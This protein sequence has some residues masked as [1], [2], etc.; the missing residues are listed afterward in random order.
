[1]VM[2]GHRKDEGLG[3]SQSEV[4]CGHG[5]QAQSCVHVL[6]KPSRFG[7]QVKSQTL[8]LVRSTNPQFSCDW[9]RW[10]CYG[11]RYGAI[12]FWRVF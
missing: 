8:L 9:L 3:Y 10:R 12:C 11:F 1:M 4:N 6:L 7:L 5:A 2:P